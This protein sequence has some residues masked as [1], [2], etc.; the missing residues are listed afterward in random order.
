MK[1]VKKRHCFNYLSTI[2]MT[3]VLLATAPSAH[4]YIYAGGDWGGKNLAL[5]DG[6]SL[7]GTFSNVGQFYIPTGAFISGSANNLVVNAGKV[8]IDGSLNGLPAPGYN[9]EL[10]SLSDFILNGSIGSWKS[11]LLSANQSIVLTGTSSI[12]LLEGGTL[13]VA[14]VTPP[15]ISITTPIPAAAWLLGSGLLGLMGIRRRK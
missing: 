9:L 5:L 11:I 6:D 3:L 1:I 8:L 13:D 4:A 10:H 14:V 7:S 2:L 15:P 12:L